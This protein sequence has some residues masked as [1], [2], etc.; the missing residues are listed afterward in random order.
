[1]SAQDDKLEAMM[2]GSGG[3]LYITGTGA[4]AGDWNCIQA[5]TACTFTVLVSPNIAGPSLNTITLAAGTT[6]HGRFSAITL[7]TGSVVAY[8]RT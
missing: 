7:A 5:I 6:L 4:N 3:G 2:T 1:M 8:N